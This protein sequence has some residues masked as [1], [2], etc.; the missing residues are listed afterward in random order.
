MA[1]GFS[2]TSRRTIAAAAAAVAGV[3]SITATFA[4]GQ[5]APPADALVEREITVTTPATKPTAATPKPTAADVPALIEQLGSD[6]WAARQAAHERLVA[7]GAA[8]EEQLRRAARE[9]ADAEVRTRCDTVLA[10]IAEGRLIGPTLVTMH[11][12]NV[13]PRLAFEELGR[14]AGID[15]GPQHASFWNVRR[16]NVTIDAEGVPFWEVVGQ[17]RHQCGLDVD[18]S[19]VGGLYV[20]MPSGPGAPTAVSGPFRVRATRITRTLSV[21]LATGAMPAS[22]FSVTL[23]IAAEPKMRISSIG[24]QPKI[25]VAEDEHGTSLLPPGAPGAGPNGAPILIAARPMDVPSR[26]A[27]VWTTAA[28][29]RYPA[30]GAGKRIAR[31]RGATSCNVVIRSDT[32]EIPDILNASDLTRP[33]DGARGGHDGELTVKSCRKVGDFYELKLALTAPAD[34]AGAQVVL[35]AARRG[36]DGVKI[37][38]GT[39]R[40]M[41]AVTTNTSTSGTRTELTL[42]VHAPGGGAPSKLVWQVPTDVRELEVPFEFKDLPLP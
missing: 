27:A 38:D 39:G 30:G 35:K 24:R 42:R 7:L 9:S 33:I 19:G 40:E 2:R 37:L 18:A 8:A 16:P 13:S 29:L 6:A 21:D 41:N 10:Q 28:R 34:A 15:L 26:A 11:L 31:L 14:S 5:N 23:S 12:A 20:M 22:D 1:H 32:L 36:T 4:P 25:E 17:I 3:V